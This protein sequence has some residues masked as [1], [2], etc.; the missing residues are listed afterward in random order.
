MR[1]KGQVGKSEEDAAIAEIL[2]FYRE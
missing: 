1:T 2:D